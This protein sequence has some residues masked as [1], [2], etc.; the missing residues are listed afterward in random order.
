MLQRDE[1]YGE[2][3]AWRCQPYC[4]PYIATSLTLNFP[5]C[6]YTA[7]RIM[8]DSLLPH[9]LAFEATACSSPLCR[10]PCIATGNR[11]GRQFRW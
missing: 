11:N 8:T 7:H 1:S 2:Q 4:E 6:T 9:S 5:L 10:S 3:S